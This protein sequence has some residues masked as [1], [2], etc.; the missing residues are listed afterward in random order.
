MVMGLHWDGQHPIGSWWISDKYE[1]CN[2]ASSWDHAQS[3]DDDKHS[4]PPPV[5]FPVCLFLLFHLARQLVIP[6]RIVH[7]I[8]SSPEIPAAWP[9]SRIKA[10]AKSKEGICSKDRGNVTARV[11]ARQKDKG[12]NNDQGK[13]KEQRTMTLKAF[14]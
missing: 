6:P 8:T 2:G 9:T 4:S 5:T 13:G 1:Y 7:T 12:K 14:I 11:S 10:R 3:I